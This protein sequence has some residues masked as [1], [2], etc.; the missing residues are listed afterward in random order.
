[1]TAPSQPTAYDAALAGLRQV[2][3]ARLPALQAVAEV[4][5]TNTV[6]LERS[7]RDAQPQLLVAERQHAGRGRLGRDWWSAPGDSL[8]FSLAWPCEGWPLDQLS[9]LSLAVGLALAEAIEPAGRRLRLKWPNDLWLDGRKLGGVLIETAASAGGAPRVVVIGVGLNLRAPQAS[10]ER[11]L[12]GP[13]AGA[14]ELDPRWSAPLLL[15]AVLPPLVELLEGWQGLTPT[16]LASYAPRDALAGRRIAG[17]GLEG[18]A[19]GVSA[20]GL[21]RLRDDAGAL[22]ELR[23]GEARLREVLPS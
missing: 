11:P 1:M 10:P 6:L 8:T 17:G 20:A 23:A 16:V 7:R 3:G 12:D 19:E 2:L 15:S 18:V 22:H 14:I 21:L 9:G 4:G 5:S 13:A